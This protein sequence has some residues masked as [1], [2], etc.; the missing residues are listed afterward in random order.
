[1]RLAKSQ[2]PSGL[3]TR[4]STLESKPGGSLCIILVR[5][6]AGCEGNDEQIMEM[7]TILCINVAKYLSSAM[8]ST[9][10]DCSMQKLT[11]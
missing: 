1:M 10:C 3:V 9:M 11:R 8:V 6:S 7:L 2:P 4:R 5:V